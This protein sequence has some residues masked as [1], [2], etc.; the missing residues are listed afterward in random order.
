MP[1]VAATPDTAACFAKPIAAA[2]NPKPSG[3]S[4]AVP[5]C[6]TSAS[7][8]PASPAV[9]VPFGYVA[10]AISVELPK[11]QRSH[12]GNPAFPRSYSSLV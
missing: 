8:K 5:A 3:D 4:F 6:L 1:P 9:R 10:G 11:R 12:K 2:A 7:S